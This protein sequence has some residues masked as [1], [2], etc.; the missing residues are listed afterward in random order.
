[1]ACY[2]DLICLLKS[3]HCKTEFG[4]VIVRLKSLKADFEKQL[5][6]N[7]KQETE[8]KNNYNLD[9]QAQ[10]YAILEAESNT[11]DQNSDLGVRKGDLFTD[12]G[13]LDDAN[14]QLTIVVIQSM[15][16]SM[17][18]HKELSGCAVN[19]AIMLA[20]SEVTDGLI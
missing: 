1:M 16:T 4:V 10:D 18:Y 7:I 12:M 11:D 3:K 9:K 19:R 14:N 13:T 6:E 17:A 2:I 8:R 15:R 20:E 5:V